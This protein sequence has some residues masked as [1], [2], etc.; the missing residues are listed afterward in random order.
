MKIIILDRRESFLNDIQTR[1]LLDERDIELVGQ[2][3]TSANIIGLVQDNKPDILLIADNIVEEQSDWNFPNCKTIGYITRKNENNPFKAQNVPFYNYV[4]NSASLLNNLQLGMPDEKELNT[5]KN[6]S[7]QES[8]NVPFETKVIQQTGMKSEEH[9]LREE[10][11]N[12]I[13]TEVNEK[14]LQMSSNQ[15][16]QNTHPQMSFLKTQ[17]QRNRKTTVV[18][19]Y[20]AKGGVGKTTISTSL[21]VYLS[22]M[23]VGR[24]YLRVCIIDCNIDFG[25]VLTT[26]GYDAYGNNLAFWAA[27]VRERLARGETSDNIVYSKEEIEAR[28]QK[29]QNTGLY[30]LI[31]PVSHEDSLEIDISEFEV[32]FNSILKN[33][34]FDYIICDTGNNT[35]DISLFALEHSDHMFLLVTQDVSTASCNRAVLSTLSK[36]KFDTSKIRLIFNQVQSSAI[37]RLAI[38]ELEEVF[39]YE[40]VAKIKRSADI[41]QANNLAKPIVLRDRNHPFTKEIQKIANYLVGQEFNDDKVQNKSKPG[42]FRRLF[43]R[44]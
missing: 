3:T 9:F 6:E 26:L 37:T 4:S 30:A 38:E 39:P 15:V 21:A 43:G 33:G 28:L 44:E 1:L 35:R 23:C 34:D 29:A 41:I 16:S 24:D 10:S 17:I 12:G 8:I 18:A 42:F 22:R 32:I 31:A 25:D 7:I 2:S 20:A 19:V 5:P 14:T 11:E 13:F 36:I 27:E 40:S